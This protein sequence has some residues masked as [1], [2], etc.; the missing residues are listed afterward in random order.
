MVG[1]DS[2]HKIAQALMSYEHVG[3]TAIDISP[4]SLAF[5]RQML[6]ETCAEE[7][8]R[9]VRFAV[10]DLLALHLLTD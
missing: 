10:G 6:H 5:T 4:H 2:G 9:R 8:T 7:T 1:S 3:I